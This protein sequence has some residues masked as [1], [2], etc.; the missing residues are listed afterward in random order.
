[1]P[2]TEA[3]TTMN[4][5]IGHQD[6]LRD[7]AGNRTETVI[8]KGISHRDITTV[9]AAVPAEAGTILDKRVEKS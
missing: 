5:V 7:E 9:E 6:H 4:F 3:G 1:M 8:A 2:S